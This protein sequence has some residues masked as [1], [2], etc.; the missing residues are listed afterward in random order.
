MSK[1]FC[2][3]PLSKFN[4]L[5]FGLKGIS[6][7][8][9]ENPNRMASRKVAVINLKIWIFVSCF[10]VFGGWCCKYMADMLMI[11]KA[12]VAILLTFYHHVHFA[13]IAKINWY[14]ARGLFK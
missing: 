6:F 1:V 5:S 11:G 3:M 7:L 9:A 12:C 14:L 8:H 10:L 2:G 13:V 4:V